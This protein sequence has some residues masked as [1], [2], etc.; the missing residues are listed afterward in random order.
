MKSSLFYV[1]IALFAT[2][3]AV[4]VRSPGTDIAA[5]NGSTRKRCKSPLVVSPHTMVSLT[6]FIFFCQVSETR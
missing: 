2:A 6:A 4:I 1:I 3:H 5:E